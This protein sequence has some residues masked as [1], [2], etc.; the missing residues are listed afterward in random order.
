MAAFSMV[1]PRS[2]NYDRLEGGMG[3]SRTGA[4]QRGWRKFG[5]KKFAIGA[6]VLIGIVWLFG[7]REKVDWQQAKDYAKGMFSSTFK[8]GLL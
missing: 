4:P 7:P 6:A 2:G 3:P 8:L 5:W 1:S